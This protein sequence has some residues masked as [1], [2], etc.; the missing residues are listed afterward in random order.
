MDQQGIGL[1]ATLCRRHRDVTQFDEFKR[2][3]RNRTD[4]EGNVSIG[5]LRHG[6]VNLTVVV[7]RE[8]ESAGRKRV[9]EVRVGRVDTLAPISLT[10]SRNR[11][12]RVNPC[13]LW[14]KWK[15]PE[16][17]GSQGSP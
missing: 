13:Q 2:F 1:H 12:P 7:T 8:S 5:L 3:C 11:S 6:A 15:N 14:R 16:S 9:P 10:T 17:R 4:F